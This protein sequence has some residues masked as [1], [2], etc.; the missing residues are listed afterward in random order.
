MI[1][2]HAH[3]AFPDFDRDREAVIDKCRRSMS[4]VIASGARLDEDVKVLGIVSK[5]AGFIFPTLGFHPT[6]KGDF[7]EVIGLIEKSRSSIVG[8]GEVGLDYH[9]E[10]DSGKQETQRKVFAEFI[11]LAE[12]LKLP[13]VIHSWD[14]EQD[15]FDMVKSRQVKTVFHCYSGSRELAVRIA[16]A[17]HYVSISTQICFSKNH[18]KIARDVPLESI[19]L[20][21]D[22]PFLSPNK[23]PEEKRNFPWNIAVSAEKIAKE[24]VI[25]TAAVLEAC[26]NNAVRAFG[27][28]L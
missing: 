6:E 11:G 23:T 13:L 19:L 22:S 12:K 17:G 27:L 28:R 14:A 16:E 25:E 20:E 10:H 8:I 24:K 2:V 9:W 21:T 1:D 18:R 26:K 5:H 7:R 15:C 4:A 3:L